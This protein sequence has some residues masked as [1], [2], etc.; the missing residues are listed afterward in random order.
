MSVE[1]RSS[2]ERIISGRRW[3]GALTEPKHGQAPVAWGFGFVANGYNPEALA[4]VLGSDCTGKVARL[5][6]WRRRMANSIETPFKAGGA[7]R[8][9]LLIDRHVAVAAALPLEPIPRFV[10]FDLKLSRPLEACLHIVEISFP[11]G[12]TRRPF[13][14]GRNVSS[15]SWNWE[16]G[17]FQL[18]GQPPQPAKRNKGLAWSLLGSRECPTWSSASGERRVRGA[19]KPR[20]TGFYVQLPALHLG[21]LAGPV[22][23]APRL[24]RVPGPTH[25][26]TKVTLG[27]GEHGIRLPYR[28]AEIVAASEDVELQLFSAIVQ[29][30]GDAATEATV[31]YRGWN[32]RYD[33]LSIDPTDGALHLSLGTD[34]ALDPEEFAAKL[35]PGHLPLYSIYTTCAGVEP[36]DLT[37]WRGLV[38][39][40]QAADHVIWL[41]ES[42]RLLPATLRKLRLGQNISLAGYGDSLTAL[43]GRDPDQIL[44]PNGRLRDTLGYFERYGNDWKASVPLF[45]RAPHGPLRHHRLGWN[46]ILKTAMEQRFGVEVEY[47]NWGLAGTTSGRDTTV[48]DGTAYPNAGNPERLARLI[49]SAPD[50]VTIAL[51]MND[52]GEAIDT[53]A[54][55]YYICEHIR[56]AGA[57]VVVIGLCPQNPG[58]NSRDPALWR[59]TH[60]SILAAAEAANVAFVPTWRIL[61]AGN[62]GATGLSPW[63][64]SSASMT[65]H[66][67]PR[68]LSAVGELLASIIP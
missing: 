21:Q 54:N 17:W 6:L 19:Q 14:V 3:S 29:R 43:G 8:D 58:F 30:V 61:G 60:D 48:I 25:E 59:Q 68:E 55:L 65:N 18:E 9:Q 53:F 66:P 39:R 23:I 13:T 12:K 35:P 38:H 45:S 37:G 5:R 7:R 57:E 20:A 10:R 63:S 22:E 26:V 32:S 27:V 49:D 41:E 52:I 24:V 64:H 33:L 42:R 44:A 67:G 28:R 1:R 56:S 2:V 50:L 31:T 11:E 36:I 46:W 47:L 15:I 40:T 16:C 62:E 4:I 51:G 34:R